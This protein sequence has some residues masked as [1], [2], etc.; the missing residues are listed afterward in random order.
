MNA[1]LIT[2]EVT[3]AAEFASI[4]P[5]FM[6]S[7][8]TFRPISNREI[9][10]QRPQTIHY[11]QADDSTSFSALAKRFKLNAEDIENLRLINGLYPKGEPEAGQ[12][13]KIFKR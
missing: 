1:Y 12:W 13:I 10:G 9:A 7:I 5:L 11:I 6:T 8:N 2:G 3:D 4:D